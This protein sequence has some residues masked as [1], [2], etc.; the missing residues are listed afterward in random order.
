VLGSRAA[1]AARCACFPRIVTM[2]LAANI[3]STSITLE[4][5]QRRW[6]DELEGRVR[7]GA[8]ATGLVGEMVGYHVGVSAHVELQRRRARWIAAAASAAVRARRAAAV[9]RTLDCSSDERSKRVVVG[10]RDPSTQGGDDGALVVV[11]SGAQ[12]AGCANEPSRLAKGRRLAESAEVVEG[13]VFR[14][15]RGKRGV[16]ADME[17]GEDGELRRVAQLGRARSW[18]RRGWVAVAATGRHVG[19]ARPRSM[20]ASWTSCAATRVFL[21]EAATIIAAEAMRLS[22]RGTPAPMSNMAAMAS[23]SK[24]G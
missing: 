22:L 20:R 6:A 1:I 8:R 21:R 18:P 19:H 7:E 2:A 24:M 10:R 23:S 5:A 11:E 12:G 9:S 16:E 13:G 14:D 4:D 17:D 3:F 15:Q